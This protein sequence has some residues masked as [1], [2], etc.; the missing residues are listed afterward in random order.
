MAKKQLWSTLKPATKER[1]RRNGVTPA[2]YNNPKRRVENRDL[3]LTAQG[4]APL[5]YAAQRAQQV[6]LLPKDRDLRLMPKKELDRELSRVQAQL[7]EAGRRFNIF[8]R[9]KFYGMDSRDQIIPFSKLSPDQQL[10]AAELWN[11]VMDTRDHEREDDWLRRK[12]DLKGHPFNRYREAD[13][14][15]A[16]TQFLGWLDEQGVRTDVE[17]WQFFRELYKSAFA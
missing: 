8:E 13:F 7:P 14:V 6:G 2:M 4:K 15:D 5:P 16:K 9:A 17:D 3:F 10:T 1:Y 11:R 12:K